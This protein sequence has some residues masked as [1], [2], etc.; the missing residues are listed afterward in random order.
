VAAQANAASR[1]IAA[2][3]RFYFRSSMMIAF[4]ATGPEP[5]TGRALIS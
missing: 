4:L 5:G 1:H 3:R 2:I